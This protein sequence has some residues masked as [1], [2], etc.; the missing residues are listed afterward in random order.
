[1]TTRASWPKANT[2]PAPGRDDLETTLDELH[3]QVVEE[4]NR[5]RLAEQR[6]GGAETRLYRLLHACRLVLDGNMSLVGL[7]TAVD[8]AVK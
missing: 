1:M 5:A 3:Q 8:E 4:G 7:Q 2:S 6:A